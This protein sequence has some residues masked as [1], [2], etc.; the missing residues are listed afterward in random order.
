M[1]LRCVRLLLAVIESLEVLEVLI[2][3]KLVLQNLMPTKLKLCTAQGSQA[4]THETRAATVWGYAD[5]DFKAEK[6]LLEAIDWESLI[7]DDIDVACNWQTWK[8]E[9]MAVMHR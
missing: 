5:T 4:G 2:E 1:H 8:R 7:V 6:E 3:L 9:F